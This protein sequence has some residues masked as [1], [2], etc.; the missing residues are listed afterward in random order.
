MRRGTE[1]EEPQRGNL[2]HMLRWASQQPMGAG[3]PQEMNGRQGA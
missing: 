3:G 2:P 1:S